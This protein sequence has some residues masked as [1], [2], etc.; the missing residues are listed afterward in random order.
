[1]SDGGP[2]RQ[3]LYRGKVIDLALETAR[4]PDG[5]TAQLEM[6]YH[7]GGT[8]VVAVR[9]SGEICLLR[10]YRQAVRGWIW[11]LP[12]GKPDGEEAPLATGQRELREEAGVEA[13]DWQSLGRIASSPGVFREII[14]L[15]C[16]RD[17]RPAAV[18]RDPEEYIE[19]HWIPLPEALG[20][21]LG[22][23]IYDAKTIVGLFRAQALLEGG[24]RSCS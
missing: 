22:G 11:E 20:W 3:W 6:I 17:L 16:A 13:A 2:E 5:T 12:A 8:A 7:P 1:M 4:F 21:A 23:E 9:G 18:H 15:F 10:Q 24:S 14:H 19:V